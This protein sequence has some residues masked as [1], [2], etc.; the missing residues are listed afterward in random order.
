M[1]A[2]VAFDLKPGID[3]DTALDP[4]VILFD[5]VGE[6]SALP[7]ADPLRES[8]RSIPQAAF[9]IVGRERLVICLAA[10]GSR[11]ALK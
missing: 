9:G 6:V 10:G 4:P 8:S 5:P 2:A 1:I 3:A 7:N 11:L